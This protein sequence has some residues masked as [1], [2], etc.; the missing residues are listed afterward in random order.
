MIQSEPIQEGQI[1]T[2]A[3]FHEPMR[4]ET[5]RPNGPDNWVVGLVGVKSEQFRKVTL[6]RTELDQLTILDQATTYQGDGQLKRSTIT[7]T[8]KGWSECN[9]LSGII[10]AKTFNRSIN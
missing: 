3:L 10:L 7:V 2:G 9:G 4:V 5:V 8:S 1:L 6:S